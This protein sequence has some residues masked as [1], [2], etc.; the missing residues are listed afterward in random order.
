MINANDYKTTEELEQAMF[1]EQRASM[2]DYIMPRFNLI[3]YTKNS[4]NDLIDYEL[5]Q[6]IS[7]LDKNKMY[8]RAYLIEQQAK[9]LLQYASEIHAAIP[10]IPD[11]KSTDG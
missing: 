6:A 1:K 8:M 11:E 3:T 4:I 7:K 9:Q 2:Y 10:L 5:E